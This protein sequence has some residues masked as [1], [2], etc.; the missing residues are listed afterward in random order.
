MA[1]QDS[2]PDTLKPKELKEVI[3]KAWQHRE[4][5]RLPEEQNGFL[6]SGKKSEVITIAGTNA[7]IAIKTAR[8]SPCKVSRIT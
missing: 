7:N 6:I 3:I 4:V 5:T 8:Q 2:A 1:Q